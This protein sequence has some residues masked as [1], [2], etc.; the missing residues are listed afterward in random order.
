MLETSEGLQTPVGF[1]KSGVCKMNTDVPATEVVP[2]K[3]T[4]ET[5]GPAFFE[6][7]GE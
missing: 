4:I 1:W 6:L 5:V 7:T 3:H 2:T